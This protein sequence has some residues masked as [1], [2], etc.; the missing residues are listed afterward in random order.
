MEEELTAAMHSEFIVSK[1]TETKHKVWALLSESERRN[2]EP[3][4]LKKQYD[5]SDS[6]IQKHMHSYLAL[7]RFG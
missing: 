2:I 5:I 7:K 3:S 1:E 6:E 4:V